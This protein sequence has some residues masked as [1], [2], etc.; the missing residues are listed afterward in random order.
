MA[1]LSFN[2]RVN[3]AVR[4]VKEQYPEANLY[5]ADGIATGGPT[6]DPA[7][8]DQLTVVFQYINSS[9]VIIKETGYGEF[10]PPEYI[11][12]PVGD[13]IVI[14]WPIEMD[15]P[16]ATELKVNAGYKDPFSNVTLRNPLM[17]GVTHPYFTFGVNQFQ[18]YINVDTVTGKVWVAGTGEGDEQQSKN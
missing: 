9:T 1:I 16:K 8:I 11:D 7:Q 12:S 18:P 17:P 4:I 6:T 13:D 15:L 14:D 5:E 10:G 3:I 2:G